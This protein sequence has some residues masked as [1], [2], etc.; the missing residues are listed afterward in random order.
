MHAHKRTILFSQAES[1][2]CAI[3]PGFTENLAY[4]EGKVSWLEAG[5]TALVTVMSLVQDLHLVPLAITRLRCVIFGLCLKPL[6][7]I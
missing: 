1:G 3:P 6:Y 4:E 2:W 5:I 7:F